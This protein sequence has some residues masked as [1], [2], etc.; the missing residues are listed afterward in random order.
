M[1]GF[2]YPKENKEIILFTSIVKEGIIKM[3]SNRFKHECEMWNTT[4]EI[5]QDENVGM[6]NKMSEI[7]HRSNT[8]GQL[9]ERAEAF[10]S[11]FLE[12][13]E[14]LR[15]FK[16]EV[17]A[18]LKET[19]VMG[20]NGELSHGMEKMRF[21]LEILKKEFLQLKNDFDKFSSE[22]VPD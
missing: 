11:R 3:I 4:V 20:E 10:Q 16:R 6:K 5:L 8:T 2:L 22:T 21:R 14:A 1:Q 9:L 18:F 15:Q 17:L 7:L 12:E 13:D 19:Y